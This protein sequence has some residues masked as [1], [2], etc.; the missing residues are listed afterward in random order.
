MPVAASG[1]RHARGRRRSLLP[2]RAS[3]AR[4]LPQPRVGLDHLYFR[5]LQNN[6]A[7]KYSRGN[8]TILDRKKLESHSCE[9]Y[10]IVKTEFDRLLG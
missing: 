9:C 5:R 4:L 10:R 8:I 2:A 6:G 3:H 7:I 1:T